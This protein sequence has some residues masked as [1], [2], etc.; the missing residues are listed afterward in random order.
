MIREP[1]TVAPFGC[2]MLILG[3]PPFVL[4][5][6]LPNQT[7][8]WNPKLIPSSPTNWSK[9]DWKPPWSP[10]SSIFAIFVLFLSCCS[11]SVFSLQPR[12]A[13]GLLSF[14]ILTEKRPSPVH[15]FIPAEPHYVLQWNPLNL[16][17][18]MILLKSCQQISFNLIFLPKGA[19][20]KF[21]AVKE[22]QLL[23][24]MT[25]VLI[26]QSSPTAGRLKESTVSL[27]Q[28][29]DVGEWTSVNDPQELS[30]SGSLHN[31][32]WWMQKSIW[33]VWLGKRGHERVS[34]RNYWSEIINSAWLMLTVLNITNKCSEPEFSSELFYCQGIKLRDL[35]LKCTWI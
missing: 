17:M 6:D 1:W 33:R 18:L 3:T 15:T 9:S 26:A 11:F 13:K 32:P 10:L 5:F 35:M 29:W 14:Y 2:I 12:S 23:W 16:S 7:I 19:S 20:H 27:G 8:V 31:P 22:W 4:H 28:E 21:L 30:L 34:G 25:A 24:N